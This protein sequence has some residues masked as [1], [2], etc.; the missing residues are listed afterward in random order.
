MLTPFCL[1]MQKTLNIYMEH[2]T[3][4]VKSFLFEIENKRTIVKCQANMKT[5]S[6]EHHMWT[7]HSSSH[8]FILLIHC[9]QHEKSF[10]L[11]IIMCSTHVNC[12]WMLERQLLVLSVETV[13]YQIRYV[14]YVC[15]N[16]Q[17]CVPNEYFL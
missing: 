1:L 9:N 15:Y 11:T 17:Q 8:L 6:K 4:M 10:F 12:G 16:L 5:N 3:W 7:E 13:E 14:Y 2:S